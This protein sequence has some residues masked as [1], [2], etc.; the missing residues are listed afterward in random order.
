MLGCLDEIERLYPSLNSTGA[1]ENGELMVDLRN[2]VRRVVSIADAM[3]TA[4]EI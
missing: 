1:G 2:H 3:R 4:N